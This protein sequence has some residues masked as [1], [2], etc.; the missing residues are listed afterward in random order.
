MGYFYIPTVNRFHKFSTPSFKATIIFK[1]N[2]KKGGG[3]KSKQAFH[4][5][6]IQNS[7]LEDLCTRKWC[8]EILPSSHSDS[9]LSRGQSPH[10]RCWANAENEKIWHYEHSQYFTCIKKK[11]S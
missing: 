9:I 3:G 11:M 8:S 4:E 1:N 5:L 10:P 2:K 6:E 7:P